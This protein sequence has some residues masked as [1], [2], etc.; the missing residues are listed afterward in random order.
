MDLELKTNESSIR[1]LIYFLVN[2]ALFLGDLVDAGVHRHHAIQIAIGLKK[3]FQLKHDEVWHDCNLVVIDSDQPHQFVGDG[4]SIIIL[5]EPESEEG[6]RIKQS[7]L[8][9]DKMKILE[10]QTIEAFLG[11]GQYYNLFTTQEA[12]E[13][14]NKII[15]AVLGVVPA[16]RKVD[17]R[18]NDVLEVLKSFPI[19]EVSIKE[20]AP[21]VFLSE[22]R[23]QHLIKEQLGIPIRQYLLW[24]RLKRAL[25]LIIAGKSLT[26]AAHEAGFAD[27]AHL[28]R[29]FKAMF[30]IKPSEMLKNSQFV[31]VIVSPN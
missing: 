1:G 14:C 31:Q 10:L 3:P 9:N 2:R 26:E 23:L 13:L 24:L 18:I 22:S 19:R 17:P 11:E 21:M 8:N 7:V 6:K 25:T 20:L 30:G 27:S 12:E 16:E 5:V 29:T 15:Y 4:F 28:S